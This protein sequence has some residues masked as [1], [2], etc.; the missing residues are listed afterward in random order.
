MGDREDAVRRLVDITG[1]HMSTACAQRLLDEHDGDVAR[2][3][4]A[5]LLMGTISTNGRSCGGSLDDSSVEQMFRRDQS[6]AKN[7]AAECTADIDDDDDGD[8]DP[9]GADESSAPLVLDFG[10]SRGGAGGGDSSPLIVKAEPSHRL[11]VRVEGDCVCCQWDV[12]SGLPV[13]GVALCPLGAPE[14]RC[15]VART[16]VDPRAAAGF[17]GTARFARTARGLYDVRLYGRGR[18]EAPVCVSDSPVRVGPPAPVLRATVHDG[19]AVRITLGPADNLGATGAGTAPLVGPRDWIGAFDANERDNTVLCARDARCSCAAAV[20]GTLELHLPRRAG[21]YDLRYFDARSA[22]GVCCGVSEAFVFEPRDTVGALA[23][24]A[25]TGTLRVRWACAASAPTRW[26][27]VGLFAASAQGA[28]AHRVTWDWCSRGVC[29]ARGDHGLVDL[30]LPAALADTLRA[31]TSPAAAAAWAAQDLAL[32][33]YSS[34]VPSVLVA[35]CA[36]PSIPPE[37]ASTA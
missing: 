22:A 12:A 23:Y 28:R 34:S 1:G 3:A 6:N 17:H 31:R 33:L 15:V 7:E 32:R 13:E 27:W 14:G 9:A 20:D 24:G 35:T 11:A 18:P 29:S 2:A 26:A 21:R 5:Y 10:R 16:A 30:V 4:E 37:P 8:D 19:N 36:L 25:A